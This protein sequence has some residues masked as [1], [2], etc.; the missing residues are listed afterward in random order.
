MGVKKIAFSLKKAM[1]L[2]R[3]YREEKIFIVILMK[4]G[5]IM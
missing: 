4:A 2:Y 1:P 5:Q 3:A